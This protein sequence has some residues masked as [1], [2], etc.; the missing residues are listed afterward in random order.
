MFTINDLRN[1]FAIEGPIKVK[2]YH[3]DAPVNEEYE[4]L[5]E[6]DAGTSHNIPEELCNT[7]ITYMYCE[8]G[9]L[10]IEL[11]SEDE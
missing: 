4:T 9:Y 5:Y 6:A 7:K 2:K 3:Y 10:V 1:Q 11:E 8:H